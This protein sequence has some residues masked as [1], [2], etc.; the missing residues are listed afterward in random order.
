M[1]LHCKSC[2]FIDDTLASLDITLTEK[3]FDREWPL[4]FPVLIGVTG[5][6]LEK[7]L[8]ENKDFDREWPFIVSVLSDVTS[9][10]SLCSHLNALYPQSPSGRGWFFHSYK[11][12]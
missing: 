5:V 12:T 11:I 10:N 9:V 3:D 6:S 1:D 2:K 4:I 7:T 8:T